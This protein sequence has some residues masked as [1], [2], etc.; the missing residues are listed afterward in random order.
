MGISE[1]IDVHTHKTV[2]SSPKSKDSESKTDSVKP[3]TSGSSN[4]I[5]GGNNKK[6]VVIAAP[7]S[8]NFEDDET[9]SP[10]PTKPV[11]EWNNVQPKY[12][13]NKQE[14]NRGRGGRGGYKRGGRGGGRGNGGYR[15][16][17]RGYRGGNRNNYSNREA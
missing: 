3:S 16:S 7:E 6:A 2:S 14:G 10:S 13:K 15:G 1:K 4:N 8:Q 5:S 9:D 12:L 17:G 11:D